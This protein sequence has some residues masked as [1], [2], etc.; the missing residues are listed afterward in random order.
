MAN[1]PEKFIKKRETPGVIAPPLLIYGLAFGAAWLLQMQQ[2][3]QIAAFNLEIGAYITLGLGAWLVLWAFMA[4]RLARTSASP[5]KPAETL[6]TGGPFR[7][8]RNPVYLAMTLL[9]LGSALLLN[10]LWPLVLLPVV[11]ITMLLGVI[12][13]EERYLL[14]RF[15][16]K[17]LKYKVSVRRWL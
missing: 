5:Y 17:Y 14:L 10:T 2:P 7:F 8:S 11:L 6:V 1:I 12:F 16:A 13:R 3:L 15:G 4:M 9:Y